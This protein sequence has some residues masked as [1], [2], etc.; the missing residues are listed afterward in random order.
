MKI[1][2]LKKIQLVHFPKIVTGRLSEEDYK[3]IKE[4]KI[5]IGVLLRLVIKELKGGKIKDDNSK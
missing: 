1:E 4:K 2:D 5:S 3:W